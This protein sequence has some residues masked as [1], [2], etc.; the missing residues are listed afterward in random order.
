[1]VTE[2]SA[3]Q[4]GL[5]CFIILVFEQIG[6]PLCSHPI[7]LV[8]CMITDRIGLHSVLTGITIIFILQ[9]RSVF[10]MYISA[11]CW[12]WSFPESENCFLS[13]KSQLRLQTTAASSWSF[14][15]NFYDSYLHTIFYFFFKRGLISFTP[16]YYGQ[17]LIT[18]Q[19]IRFL[20]LVNW[21]SC[22]LSSIYVPLQ[23]SLLS[24]YSCSY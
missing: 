12:L 17:F 11:H 21:Y 16:V 19:K 20:F 5:V 13:M 23:C 6:L 1:M 7:L 9:R 24:L 22:H 14:I 2:L 18:G 3:I 10:K 4:F 8:I 15:N